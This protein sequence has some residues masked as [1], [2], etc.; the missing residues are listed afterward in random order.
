MIGHAL[1]T[2]WPLRLFAPVT[3]TGLPGSSLD[4]EAAAPLAPS[5]IPTPGGSERRDFSVCERAY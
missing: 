2:P 3:R 5:R 1:A 4:F